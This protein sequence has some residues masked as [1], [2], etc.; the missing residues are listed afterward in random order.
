MQ[1]LF[2][3]HLD[4]GEET[5]AVAHRHALIL[6]MASFKTFLFGILS[7][8]AFF[9]FFPS[10]FMIVLVWGA[11]GLLGMCYHFFDWYFD[12]WLLTNKGVIDIE[13]NGLFDRNSTRVDYHMIEGIAYTVKGVIPTIFN[14]GDIVIDKL[15]AATT[16]VL[17]DA[18]NPKK[19]ERKVI[20]YQE[21][22]VTEKSM[23]DHDVL[24]TMLAEMV[25]HHV[26]SGDIDSYKN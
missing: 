6:K 18:T 2:S 26:K 10:A 11:M 5:I 19:V 20:K 22:F 21:E 24:K 15:G 23:R 12:A 17:K 14:Y 16:L 1:F 7:P 8:V 25:A 9:P 13:Q 4:E 3:S